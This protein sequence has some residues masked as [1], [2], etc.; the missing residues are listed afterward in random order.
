MS[1]SQKYDF[2]YFLIYIH[3]R[4]IH[5]L[6]KIAQNDRN[7][8]LIKIVGAK[9]CFGHI[10]WALPSKNLFFDPFLADF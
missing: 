7:D 9:K 5:H 4:S 10:I 3:G 1:L 6:S 2:W 8:E